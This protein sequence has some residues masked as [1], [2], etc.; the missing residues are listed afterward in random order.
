VTVTGNTMSGNTSGAVFM[1]PYSSWV[2]VNASNI[3]SGPIVVNSGTVPHNASWAGGQVYYLPGLVTVD[4]VA[5]VGIGAG[6]ILKFGQESRIDVNGTL[7]ATGTSGNLVYFT[8]YRDDIGGDT[9]GDGTA[10]SPG[11]GWWRGINIGNGGSATLDYC[12]IRYSTGYSI[13]QVGTFGGVLK[14][15]SG[16][17]TL[18]NSIVSNSGGAGVWLFNTTATA[19]LSGNTIT[20]NGISGVLLDNASN[21]ITLSGNYLS[22]NTHSGIFLSGSSTVPLISGNRI[23]GNAYGIYVSAGANPVIGGTEANGNDIYSN[24]NYGVYNDTPSVTVNARYNWWDSALGPH[25]SI[26]NP[27]GTGN[28]VSDYIDFSNFLTYW[29]TFFQTLT[30]DLSGTGT[31]R[32]IVQALSLT[33]NAD[34]TGQAHKG[35]SLTLQAQQEID[36]VFDGWSVG[37]CSGTGDCTLTMDNDT[38]VTAAYRG[39]PPIA[40]FSGTPLSGVEPLIVSFTDLSGHGPYA[41]LWGFGDGGSSTRQNPGHDYT[42]PGTYAVVITATNAYGS[43]TETKNGYITVTACPNGPASILPTFY[44]SL[45]AAYEVAGNGA[46]IRGRYKTLGSLNL[47]KGTHVNLTGGVRLP[48]WGGDRHNNPDRHNDNHHRFV[49]CGKYCHKIA[50]P[51]GASKEAAWSLTCFFSTHNN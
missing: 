17:L 39:V 45:Q 34:C 5:T 7:N 27:N 51:P 41:W 22:G 30:L 38:T 1:D 48:P 29:A 32:V 19:T 43:D 31:G 35:Q 18:T 25:H 26:T 4:A 46:I 20:T 50:G 10:S 47:N 44:D 2:P 3:L 21:S 36:S 6:A 8:D 11:Q 14:T 33:C 9:N 16:S 23:N 28:D 13:Y 42:D 24:T 37:G 40:D 12:S 15:G 49:G